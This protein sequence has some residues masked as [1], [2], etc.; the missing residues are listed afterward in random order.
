MRRSLLGVVL[1]AV[2]LARGQPTRTAFASDARA[3]VAGP[4]WLGVAM[5]PLPTRDGVRISHVIR[6]SPADRAGI[7]AGDA[8]HAIDGTVVASAQ[9]VTRIV[10][11][12][13]VGDAIVAALV[14][15]SSSITLRVSLDER[16]SPDD[17]TRMDLVGAFA[18][19]WSALEPVGSAPT[20][21]ESLHGKVVLLDFWATWCAPCRFLAP[22]LSAMQARHGAEGLQV[23]GVTTDGADKVAEFVQREGLKYPMATD[24]DGATSRA[25]S[26]RVLPTLVVIDKRG[27]VRDVAIG[28]EPRREAQIEALVQK[29]LAEPSP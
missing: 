12:H 28:Y 14:R 19:A 2:G 4:A 27:V 3:D 16:P 23:V 7:H 25:Y 11:G 1:V 18:P 9:D 5:E 15:A 6:S 10:A 26:V 17:V 21:I 8:I 29:L 13:R 22:R 24:A 20:H